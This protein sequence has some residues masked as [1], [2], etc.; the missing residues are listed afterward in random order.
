MNN[1]HLITCST[2][3]FCTTSREPSILLIESLLRFIIIPSVFDVSIY[4]YNSAASSNLQKY[5]Y[6]LTSHFIQINIILKLT[7]HWL[8][9]L[10]YSKMEVSSKQYL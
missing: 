7:F 10:V 4:V 2:I 8:D 9:Q 1:K 6:K 5:K 3:N